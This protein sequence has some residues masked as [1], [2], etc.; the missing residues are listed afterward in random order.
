MSNL[1]TYL[2]TIYQTVSSLLICSPLLVSCSNFNDS[3]NE[4]SFAADIDDQGDVEIIYSPPKMKVMKKYTI[5][6]KKQ[7]NLIS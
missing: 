2:K 7:R 1:P 5:F 6:F 3:T 4:V